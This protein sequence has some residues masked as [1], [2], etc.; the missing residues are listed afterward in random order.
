MA[1]SKYDYRKD[2]HFM[3]KCTAGS[4][5]T[6]IILSPEQ[7]KGMSAPGHP[8]S[9]ILDGNPETYYETP[10]VSSNF[11]Y[12][13]FLDID[14]RGVYEITSVVLYMIND[15]YYHY[16]IYASETG[17]SYRKIAW[18]NDGRTHDP[19]NGDCYD[20]DE[21]VT[22]AYLRINLSYHS[23][24]MQG[25]LSGLK[26]FGTKLRD[27]EKTELSGISVKD[28]DETEWKT[29]W[30]RF[31]NDPVY[32]KEK[33]LREMQNM[34]GRVLGDAW[35]N[36][37]DFAFLKA[38]HDAYEIDNGP[39]GTIVIRGTNGVAMAS[40][41]HYY[42]R[43]YCKVDYN[44]L[45]ASQMKMPDSLPKVP[46][47]IFRETPYPIRY[48]FHVCAHSYT[49]PFW[50][51][52]QY[53]K[54]LDWAAMSGVNLVLHML[55]Q[56][57]I[58]RRTLTKFGYTDTEVKEYIPAPTY[59]TW[60]CRNM[61]GFGGPLPDNW[62]ADRVEL[63][64]RVHD[65]MQALGMKPVL[66]G[67]YG[68]VPTDFTEKNP[69]ARV[70]HQGEW[71]SFTRPDT[72]RVYTEDGARDYYSEAADAFYEAQ[73]KLFG[74][75]TDYYIADPF[76]EGGSGKDIDQARMFR[77]I[78]E[79]MLEHNPDSIWVMQK[80]GDSV[81]DTRLAGLTKKRN[82]LLLDINCETE[83]CTDTTEGNQLPWVW[84]MIN[85][86]GGKNGMEANF[87]SVAEIPETLKKS[88]YMVGVGL[89]SESFS[90][91]PMIYELLWD[92]AWTRESPDPAEWGRQ[93]MEH[94]YGSVNAD[95][96][97]AWDILMRT[98]YACRERDTA[99]AL[100]NSRPTEVYS[101]T[102]GYGRGNITYDVEA[103]EGAFERYLR[104]YERYKDSECF[105]Y[106]IVDLA[107]QVL[108]NSS[109]EFH[110]R[111]MGAYHRKDREKFA[112]Y[113]ADF[114]DLIQLQNDILETNDCFLT[115]KWIGT[116]RKMQA[117]RDDWSRDQF[118]WNA[119]CLIT[120]WGG[121]RAADD[122]ALR[123][124]SYRSWAGITEDLYK[125]RWELWIANYKTALAE[126][127][128][129][130]QI[131]WFP[132]EWEW[133]NRKSDEGFSYPEKS[134][135][136]SDL[137]ALLRKAYDSYTV[138][139]L[140]KAEGETG[141]AGAYDLLRGKLLSTSNRLSEQD[142]YCLTNGNTAVGWR[143]NPSDWPLEFVCDF[144]GSTVYA[145]EIRIMLKPLVASGI[146]VTFKIEFCLDGVWHVLQENRTGNIPGLIAIPCSE[147]LQKL[148]LTLDSSGREEIPELREISLIGI[149]D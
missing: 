133:A 147:R 141:D 82:V 97:E 92:M 102:S 7:I 131:E 86:F 87:R 62:F 39:D 12:M 139:A 35:K 18:K 22:A 55:G 104:C 144:D 101:K 40:G 69:D 63:G 91:C 94:R 56:E 50:E 112:R 109:R 66:R 85:E 67:Y 60:G 89:T 68:A 41:L 117:A 45:F 134:T 128:E 73:K 54:C 4:E 27:K 95:L 3:K 65:R 121:K 24:G 88:R 142:L 11:D 30:D 149:S 145:K 64:R 20:F 76:M 15:G 75:V 42:L 114:L 138:T 17:E 146:P 49:M 70:V 72:L 21:P 74:D 103:L 136:T 46:E 111:M 99:E 127:K 116:A 124:Y 52:E 122:G 93:Y 98:V 5:P 19:I 48:C 132:V 25:N 79:K 6:E 110:K 13:R 1:E 29:E 34:V 47:K 96:T 135:Q 107:R 37:F 38:E 143:G 119:R 123:D 130:E 71:C 36:R 78:H 81:T 140:K 59:F 32:A 115:G 53:E 43:F 31:V 137:A 108:A 125:K 26:L 106:D 8:V 16:Q 80:W 9:D 105:R 90:R 23:T 126:N 44:P 77:T 14:L 84:G 57:E 120:T 61:T 83:C 51:W 100:L 58:L 148:R 33:T 118:E 2:E 113:S 129:P 10:E 28:F